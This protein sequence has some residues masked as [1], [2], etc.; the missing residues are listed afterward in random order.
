MTGKWFRGASVYQIYPRSFKDSDGD[1]VG[2]LRGIIEKIDWI[3]DLGVDAVWLCPI[4]AS[5]QADNGYDISDYRAIHPEFGTMADF[6]ELVALMHR[7]GIKLIMDMVINHS[8]D[9]HPWF[10]ESRSSKGSPKRSWYHWRP[11]GPSGPPNDWR[12]AFGGSAWTLDPATGEYYLHLFHEKQPDLNWE[13][14]EFREEI[15]ATM[16]WWLEKGV[17]GFRLDVINLISK[18]AGYPAG[19]PE[20]YANGPKIHEYLRE[21]NRQVFSP[22]GAMTVGETPFVDTSL[23]RLYTAEDRRELDMVFQ[24]EMVDLDSGPGGKWDIK[25][26]APSD[27]VGNMRKWQEALR[28]EGWNSLFWGNHDQ[29]RAI[30]R[31]GD[32]ATHRELSGKMLA[33]FLYLQRGTAFIYQGEEIGMTNTPFDSI[34]ELRDVESLNYIEE[35]RARGEDLPDLFR[36]VKLK[37]R[38]NARTPFCWDSSP[39]AGFTIGVPWIRVHPDYREVNAA[40]ALRR[41]DSIYHFY[42]KLLEL[43]R[44]E[45]LVAN[46]DIEFAGEPEGPLFLYR[47]FFDDA[48]GVR[49]L[50]VGGLFG[51]RPASSTL[52]SRSG[53]PV[54]CNYDRVEDP[55][56]WRPW[57]FRAWYE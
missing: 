13:C 1:G 46:G 36:R 50:W 39:N 31:F 40:D 5:P 48:G 22:F 41:P 49:S 38:D 34:A 20:H 18:E 14:S 2:D 35:G 9:E 15:Y 25:P 4:Y 6:D 23:C 53:G 37:G 57:E 54:L 51:D 47:R 12:S 29:P 30:S 26:I 27:V 19:G 44:G 24:F 56:A 52:T 42:R 28:R 16:R 10:R 43:R 3:A 7:H 8:S 21:M 55:L 32:P 33:G 11:A 17:D 45:D